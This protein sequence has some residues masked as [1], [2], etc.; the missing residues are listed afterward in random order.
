MRIIFYTFILLLSLSSCKKREYKGSYDQETVQREIDTTSWD[1][2]Y[3]HGGTLPIGTGNLDDELIGTKWVLLKYV[4][5]FATEYPNDTLTFISRTKY[6]LNN[7]AERRYQ[8]GT[9]TSSTNKELTLNHFAPFNGSHYSAQVGQYFIDDGEL[10][11]VEFSDIQN[12][13]TTI[14]AWFEKIN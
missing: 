5:A 9:I 3:I 14:R 10:N 8:L 4:S 6:I 1:D 13:S 11:N 7:D 2:D 12:T